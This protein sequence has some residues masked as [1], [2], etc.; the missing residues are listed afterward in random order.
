[1]TGALWSG[2]TGVACRP[3]EAG[4]F[5]PRDTRNIARVACHP[6]NNWDWPD[7]A[8][9]LVRAQSRQ[10]AK[11]DRR[12]KEHRGFVLRVGP[13]KAEQVGILTQD[14]GGQEALL[15]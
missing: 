2:D 12:G 14:G 4:E 9:V 5:Q 11:A 3:A 6:C 15:R 1:M 8:R 13:G 7:T 10:A